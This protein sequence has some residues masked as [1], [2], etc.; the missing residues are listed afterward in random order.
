M[1]VVALFG[2]G[3][4]AA[5][6]EARRSP[7]EDA[8]ADDKWDRAIGVCV[9]PEWEPHAR[10]AQA[11]IAFDN[12]ERDKAL[13]IALA[14]RD[15]AVDADAAFLA[16]RIEADTDDESAE[17]R[18]R[19]HLLRAFEGFRRGGNHKRAARAAMALSR[20]P[21]PNH[22]VE[23]RVNAALDADAEAT[24]SGDAKL[25]GRA[26]LALAE[27]YDVLGKI[28]ES[29]DLFIEAEETLQLWPE[30]VAYAWFKHALFLLDVGPT[31]DLDAVLS[32]LDTAI[33]YAGRASQAGSTQVLVN[34]EFA[35][36]LNRAVAMSRQDRHDDADRELDKLD[37]QDSTKVMMVRGIIA[38]RRGDLAAATRWFE[39]ARAGRVESD[40][41]WSIETE[42]GRLHRNAGRFDEAEAH[43]REAI[44]VIEEMRSQPSEVKLRPWILDRRRQPYVELLTMLIARGYLP[45][46]LEIAESLHA[47]AW[48]DVVLSQ[49]G[50]GRDA[51]DDALRDQR[52]AAAPPKPWLPA[53]KLVQLVG[54]REALIFVEVDDGLW[55]FH[56]VDGAIHVQHL[57]SEDVKTIEA[58]RLHLDEGLAPRASEILLPANLTE[59]DEPLI[60][61]GEVAWQT[62]FAAL[63]W[64]GGPFVEARAT[65][66]LPGLA[67]LEC[68][69]GTWDGGSVVLGDADGDLE[70]AAKE[71]ARVAR[72]FST[73]GYTGANATWKVLET[74]ARADHLH[75]AVHGRESDGAMALAL[76]DADVTASQILEARIAPRV[77]VLAGCNT[78]DGL[79]TPESWSGFPS[80]FLA[81]G[82]RF[83]ISTV[84]S[85][86]DASA[87]VVVDAY[88]NQPESLDPSRR[89]AAAQRAVMKSLPA[90]QWASFTAWGSP[91]CDFQ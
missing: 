63:P 52:L 25:G 85:V 41:R 43:Y 65:I 87:A 44:E 4:A 64:R 38:A 39:Q 27:A 50:M 28:E 75:L 83:V 86:E 6:G 46:A 20:T 11:Y 84:Q 77:V 14:L 90:P 13:P 22:F 56:L 21:R 78:A 80:A 3:C 45:R 12:G 26:K 88:Y 51:V 35:V 70:N 49:P 42:L 34:L 73:T 62:P 9:G 5:S 33:E 23:D 58:Y 57:D 30:E 89:L 47:R 66:N 8:L 18:G 61:I 2:I 29:R 32:H 76:K 54:M 10:L 53:D 19:E 74:S 37:A 60:L 24:A 79:A 59:T 72:R 82:S 69:D 16:G 71:V 81:A 15:T 67:A 36:T 17:L 48:L 7:C 68:R 91:A 40:Y 31:S 1:Q 55:R